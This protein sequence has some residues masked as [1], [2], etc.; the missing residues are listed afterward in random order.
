MYRNAANLHLA[1]F[2]KILHAYVS[3]L[4]NSSTKVAIILDT[5]KTPTEEPKDAVVV[6]TSVKP[7][8]QVHI[9][10]PDVATPNQTKFFVY[11]VPFTQ[12]GGVHAKSIDQ[13]W[14]RTTTLEVDEPFPCCTPRQ[15]VVRQTVKI[16]TPIENAIDDISMRIETMSGELNRQ[17][18]DGAD[19]NNLMRIVQGSVMPQVNGGT[20]QVAQV[21]L[22]GEA[23]LANPQ[24]SRQL[25]V[26]SLCRLYTYDPLLGNHIRFSKLAG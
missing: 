21:L 9:A 13:Q 26:F 12:D 25:E 17:K 10:K 2:Q 1:D 8:R 14:K 22:G 4:V 18:K 15:R 5:S 19:T 23:S 6:I 7:S 16:L 24:A 20:A 3:E 11:S